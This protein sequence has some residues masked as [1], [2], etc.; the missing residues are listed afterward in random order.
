MTNFFDTYS[1]LDLGLPIRDEDGE[2]RKMVEFRVPNS[3]ALYMQQVGR[4]VRAQVPPVQ[5]AQHKE[6][7]FNFVF[8]AN[9]HLTTAIGARTVPTE[10]E[11][12]LCT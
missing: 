4:A 9:K 5:A 2:I 8:D 6:P 12:E 11:A 10:K 1:D 3:P 7:L